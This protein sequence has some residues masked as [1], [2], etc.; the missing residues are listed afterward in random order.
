MKP[1]S[2]A[3]PSARA[4]APP[5]RDRGFTLF[6]AVLALLAFALAGYI[7]L[8]EVR[9]FQHRAKRDRFI[10]ELRSLAAAFEIY[11]AQKGEWPPATNPEAR[12][13]R[14]M[15]A[16]LAK[17]PWPAGSALGGS[18]DWLPPAKTVPADKEGEK[19]PPPAG[20]IAVTAFSPGPP[21]A[22]SD[23]DLR[24]IDRKLDDGDPATGRFRAGFNRWPVYLI[25]P[26]P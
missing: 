16:A 24:Y 4:P 20:T 15:E 18:Y 7:A 19:A 5:P 6:G 12:I 14:G 11:R 21:L 8:G 23:E 22:L 9:K 26:S 25:N 17:T 3:S 13:P 2:S 1:S 10:G